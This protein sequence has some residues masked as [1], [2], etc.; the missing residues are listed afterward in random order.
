MTPT[1][2][3]RR[4]G[5][6]SRIGTVIRR[7]NKS[8]RLGHSIP[9]DQDAE[10]VPRSCDGG[11]KT[12]PQ[13]TLDIPPIH[14]TLC[15]IAESP[16]REAEATQPAG[17]WSGGPVY[18]SSSESLTSQNATDSSKPT[19]SS[20]RRISFIPPPTNQ[21]IVYNELQAQLGSTKAPSASTEDERQ[22]EVPHATES[23]HEE[24]T[25]S[26]YEMTHCNSMC[27]VPS[28]SNLSSISRCHLPLDLGLGHI[29]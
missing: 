20:I 2:Q 7:T 3:K 16:L 13:V 14:S 4:L 9:F 1:S 17:S 25:A 12:M 11:G 22:A 29:E 24:S 26:F 18:A 15:T 27:H 19:P 28:N 5:W 8:H 6:P 10:F 21:D 23:I